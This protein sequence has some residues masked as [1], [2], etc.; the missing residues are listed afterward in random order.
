MTAPAD[1]SPPDGGARARRSADSRALILEAAVGCLVEEGYAGASTLA[2]QARAG[3]SRGRLQHHFPSRAELLVAAAQYLATSSLAE[4]Q[5][6]ATGLM[7]GQPA[8]PARVDQAIDLMW[9]PIH[10][11]PFRDALEHRT[12]ARTGPAQRRA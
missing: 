10:A 11:P 5:E 9:A 6:R 8:G 2:V 7:A 4:L 12:A 1:P 3:V